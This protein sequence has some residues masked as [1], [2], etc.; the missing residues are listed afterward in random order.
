MMIFINGEKVTQNFTTLEEACNY[1]C[2]EPDSAATALNHNFVPKSDRK[3]TL[4]SDGD[5]IEII[6]PFEGG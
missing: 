3:Q 6:T 2:S 4:L 5:Q 1:Y